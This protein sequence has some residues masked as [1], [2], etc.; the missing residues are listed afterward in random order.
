[1]SLKAAFLKDVMSHKLG[2][3]YHIC[4]YRPQS[5]MWTV[6]PFQE[7]LV[8]KVGVCL[9]EPGLGPVLAGSYSEMNSELKSGAG[10]AQRAQHGVKMEYTLK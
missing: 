9:Q 10:A 5:G 6:N 3:I 2:A 8:L 4:C 1:M 7:H